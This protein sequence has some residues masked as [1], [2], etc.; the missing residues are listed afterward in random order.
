MKVA[1][2]LVN[3]LA[4]VFQHDH[5]D[6]IAETQSLSSSIGFYLLAIFTCLL[7]SFGNDFRENLVIDLQKNLIVWKS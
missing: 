7:R 4:L 3:S 2:D 1:D 5:Q 6:A